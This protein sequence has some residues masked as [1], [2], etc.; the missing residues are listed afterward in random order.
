MSIIPSRLSKQEIWQSVEEFRAKQKF[1]T[2]KYPVPII[3]FV[4]HI[5]KL[6]IIPKPR[7]RYK[8]DLD[9]FISKD[10]K[11]MY[12]DQD[13]YMSPKQENR[14]RFTF[15]HEVGHFI[16]HRKQ[17]ENAPF[18]SKEEWLQFRMNL[19]EEND[20]WFEW[21]AHEFAGRL[22]V[23]KNEL[24]NEIEK[25]R[26]K[27]DQFRGVSNSENEDMIKDAVSKSICGKFQ[28]S[29]QVIYRR[30]NSENIWET[31]LN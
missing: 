6:N 27:I 15:A 9:G 5:L 30:I 24:I 14:L 29:D 28:V 20:S 1:L 16:L 10:M 4:E 21:Q 23:P 25:L 17:I 12:I 8:T 26:N 19:N 7:L 22:L 3:D 31:F 2:E 13:L 11:S 18:D